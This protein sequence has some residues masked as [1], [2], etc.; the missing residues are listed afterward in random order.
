MLLLKVGEVKAATNDRQAELNR[1]L[2]VVVR[3]EVGAIM[4]AHVPNIKKPQKI[5]KRVG[6]TAVGPEDD[7]DTSDQTLDIK[8]VA[9]AQSLKRMLLLWQHTQQVNMH[10]DV[11]AHIY[12]WPV[13]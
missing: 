9:Q 2:L 10:L 13:I 3:S 1:W 12:V 7:G 11:L 6:V 8:D 5:P 4:C